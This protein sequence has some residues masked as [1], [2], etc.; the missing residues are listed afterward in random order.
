MASN[1]VPVHVTSLDKADSIY[2]K[3]AGHVLLGVSHVSLTHSATFRCCKPSLYVLRSGS[4][5][6]VRADES[7][8]SARSSG[9]LRRGSRLPGSCRGR[10]TVLSR[11]E[12]QRTCWWRVLQGF[13]K[14]KS[15]ESTQRRRMRH[16][17]YPRIRFYAPSLS[18]HAT[19]SQNLFR[20]KILFLL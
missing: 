18:L 19:G 4:N 20:L 1:L 2:E 3:H 13:P 11:W 8:S 16:R 5:R 17:C 14:N 12:R 6:G 7:V 15:Y 9:F 10:Q